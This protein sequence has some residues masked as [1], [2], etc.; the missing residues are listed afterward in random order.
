VE[1]LLLC[2][3][4]GDGVL[5][6]LDRGTA[7]RPAADTDLVE[8]LGKV[9]DSHLMKLYPRLKNTCQIF[10][11]GP[12]I[13]P[14]L[15]IKIKKDFIAFKKVVHINQFDNKSVFLN[16]FLG[17][18]KTFFG[19]VLHIPPFPNILP[20]GGTENLGKLIGIFFI[21]CIVFQPDGRRL[22]VS[23]IPTMPGFYHI[24]EIGFDFKGVFIS[25]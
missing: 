25:V 18:F 10:D 17:N 21:L 16:L 4:Q 20:G 24:K 12:E 6:G 11:Q 5:M 7:K 19:L 14:C 22:H 15:R 2:H 23:H 13:H 9:P 1:I 8:K 3:F